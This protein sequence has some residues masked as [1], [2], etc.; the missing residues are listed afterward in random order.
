MHKV[1]ILGGG[2]AGLYAARALRGADVEVTVI[3]RRNFHLFQPLLYQVATGSLSP[4][5]IAAPLRGVLSS[6][7]NARVFM[8]EAVDID[9]ERRVVIL[10]D[11]DE[12]HYDTLLVATGAQNMYFGH[13]DWAEHAPGL[14]SIED[15]TR[16]RHK[17]FQAF[18]TAER[19]CDEKSRCSWLTF[20]IV[21]GGPTGV[22]LA[23]AVAEISRDTLKNDFRSI[24]PEEAR[25]FLV[26]GGGRLLETFPTDL[27]ADA[28]RTLV[29]LGVKPMPNSRVVAIDENGVELKGREGTSRI[30][31]KTVL[32]A[33]GVAP[34]RLGKTL[35]ERAGAEINKRGQVLVQPDLTVKG[36][37]E[38]LVLGDLAYLEQDGKPVPGVA[39]AA[40]Q[41]GKY[42]AKLIEDRLR[43]ATTDPFHYWNKGNLAVIGRNSA[44]ADFGKVR[45]HGFIAWVLWVFVHLMYLVQ[46]RSRILVFLQWGLEY[47]SFNRSARLITGAAEGLD[48][49]SARVDK[50]SGA[51]ASQVASRPA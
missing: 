16:I 20:V 45:L 43:G 22:E 4:G 32:W 2:F 11:G 24:E 31:A 46:F 5:D 49:P 17:I 18:E 14:K 13:D 40:M 12:V 50:P 19:E 44:V 36:H 48:S 8:G 23:G 35:S 38:I 6:Q 30:E 15:A 26:E 28:E 25:I 47:F 3:D 7:K 9:A 51:S 37:P 27:S 41:M 1:V 10:E 34:S 29:R 42:A 39:P 21:G 33:A